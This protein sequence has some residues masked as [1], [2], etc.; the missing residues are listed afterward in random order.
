M[1]YRYCDK[2]RDITREAVSNYDPAL[3]IAGQVI[4]HAAATVYECM[5]YRCMSTVYEYSV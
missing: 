3:A 2:I 5:V 1:V 4:L